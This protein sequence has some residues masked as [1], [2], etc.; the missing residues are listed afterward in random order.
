M[1]KTQPITNKPQ[2]KESVKGQLDKPAVS[3]M[4]FVPVSVDFDLG[5]SSCER[6][7]SR[8]TKPVG[9]E[10]AVDKK[11]RRAL[12][13][14]QCALDLYQERWGAFSTVMMYLIEYIQQVSTT[15]QKSVSTNLAEAYR[16]LKNRVVAAQGDSKKKH[17]GEFTLHF[18]GSG[19]A[20]TFSAA[21]PIADAD[22]VDSY[23]DYIR[24]ALAAPR[25]LAETSV[26]QI[27]NAW[28]H[29][30]GDCWG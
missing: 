15:I 1:K 8:Q 16:V 7:Q 10:T 30:L 20:E 2:M 23:C 17:K 12:E 25:I 19:D 27:V 13:K 22:Y 9:D 11:V 5:F 28:E 4:P 26:Q 14:E 3:K 29:F 21:F 24:A 18:K 6:V